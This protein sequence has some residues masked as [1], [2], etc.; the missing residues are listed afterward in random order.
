MPARRIADAIS[1]AL[2]QTSS[3]VVVVPGEGCLLWQ[4]MTTE[5]SENLDINGNGKS[6]AGGSA[7]S[8]DDSP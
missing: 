5:C 2:A 1:K 3:V 8:R 4:P 6:S 7:I